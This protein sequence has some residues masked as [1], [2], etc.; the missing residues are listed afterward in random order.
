VSKLRYELPHEDDLSLLRFRNLASFLSDEAARSQKADYL[1]VL[2][3]HFLKEFKQR[4]REF[5]ASGG[6][7]IVPLPKFEMVSQ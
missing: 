3:W 4:E 1:L 2:R 7:F 6:K 5:L